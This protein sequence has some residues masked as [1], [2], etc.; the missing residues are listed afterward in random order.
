MSRVL[1]VA[2]SNAHV[3]SYFHGIPTHVGMQGLRL[4]KRPTPGTD[5]LAQ[6]NPRF[7][8][9]WKTSARQCNE[10]EPRESVPNGFVLGDAVRSGQLVR[11]FFSVRPAQCKKSYDGKNSSGLVNGAGLCCDGGEAF[12]LPL[13]SQ[14]SSR[15]HSHN[16][17]LE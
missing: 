12:S 3:R 11:R 8:R 2:P 9:C 5:A 6:F 16:I 14:G 17:R 15:E 7:D 10:Q 13:S 4:M 1:S